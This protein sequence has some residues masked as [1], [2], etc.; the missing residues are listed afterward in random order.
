[1]RTT[2]DIL[3]VYNEPE[4]LESVFLKSAGLAG[5]HVT[6]VDNTVADR[7]LPD[8]FNEYKSQSK[9]DWIVFCHQDF[10][11]FE[12]EWLERLA[13]LSPDACYGPVGVSTSGQFLGRIRQTDGTFLGTPVDGA[14]VVGLDEQCL[15]APRAIFS[16][17]DFDSQFPF[18]LY[19][20][21]YCLSAQRSGFRTRIF[22]LDCQHRSKTLT[23]SVTRQTY[24]DA[25][26]AYI[27]KHKDVS[28]LFTTTFTWRP[29]YWVVPSDSVTLR[30]ELALI[31]GGSRVLEVGTAS[32]AVSQ[33]L[34]HKGCEVTGIEV[35]PE[36]AAMAERFCR[37]MIVGNIEDLDLDAE[38]SETFDIV[39][40][41][42]VIEHLRDPGAAIQRLRR[43]LSP[44]GYFVVSLPNVS[45]GAVR[46]NL[47]DGHFRYTLEGLLDATHVRLFTLESIVELFN[48]S[49]LKIL[50]LHRTRVGF[51]ETEISV[52][53]SRLS[54]Q[55]AS[56]LVS[57]PEA[58]VY[59]YVFRAVP[60]TERNTLGALRD[61]TFDP[62]HERQA[63][64]ESCMGRAFTAFNRKP[65]E[66]H[67]ARTWARLALVT[68]PRP[69]AAIYWV[70]SFAPRLKQLIAYGSR[71]LGRRRA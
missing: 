21:D 58:T 38:L 46:L 71:R 45:H 15:I 22:Q 26:E 49:E 47:L 35:D 64:A 43:R 37:R 34:K 20:H 32:G 36:L 1:M 23:G 4:T 30:T 52:H 7:G 60:S 28:P 41:G 17:T 29:K 54:L 27:R 3:V 51:F 68:A 11:V 65:P 50:D 61:R 62:R 40:C 14:D 18:D 12:K 9:A 44:G 56:R 19:A 13:R 63:F 10:I 25:K 53:L 69:K 70:L 8:I 42:D 5:A 33:A 48:A 2:V 55:A 24:L 66:G 39:L 6:V 31:P 16:T 59:Q 57:D 67:A